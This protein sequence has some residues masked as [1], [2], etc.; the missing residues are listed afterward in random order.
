MPPPLWL[1]TRPGIKDNLLFVQDQ[2]LTNGRDEAELDYNCYR[3]RDPLKETGNSNEGGSALLLRG[4]VARPP[5]A[6]T[7]DPH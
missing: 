3:R 2:F 4:P 5:G 7:S 1:R 6:V